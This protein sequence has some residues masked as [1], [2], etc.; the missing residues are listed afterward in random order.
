MSP[1]RFFVHDSNS[2]L[3]IHRDALVI[4]GCM[5]PAPAQ[6]R[7]NPSPVPVLS[8]KGSS[9]P[10]IFEN[11][12]ATFFCKR[13]HRRRAD[14]LDYVVGAHDCWIRDNEKGQ[15]TEKEKFMHGKFPAVSIVNLESCNPFPSGITGKTNCLCYE[16]ANVP[17]W[18]PQ[19]FHLIGLVSSAKIHAAFETKSYSRRTTLGFNRR[20]AKLFIGLCEDPSVMSAFPARG[21]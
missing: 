8:S 5:L 2:G 20:V 15:D 9:C 10:V 3:R 6:N 19:H 17:V 14:N 16:T 21:F 18:I 1:T 12:S 11:W 4:S 7:R 13:I